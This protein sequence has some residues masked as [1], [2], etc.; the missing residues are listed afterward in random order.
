MRE[1]KNKLSNLG[2]NISILFTT[3]IIFFLMFEIILNFMGFL[4]NK[5]AYDNYDVEW[6]LFSQYDSDLGWKGKPFA[7]GYSK[8]D[9]SWIDPEASNK[10][11]VRNNSDGF[12][13]GEFD[14]DSDI[15]ILG[16]SIVWGYGVSE[17]DMFANILVQK[18]N[19]KIIN[20]GL[21]G[22]SPDQE[23]LLYERLIDKF[24]FKQTFLFVCENDFED[25]VNPTIPE[26]YPKPLF[27][28]KDNKLLLASVPAI[29]QSILWK[30]IHFM[31]LHSTIYNF[32]DV[33]TNFLLT[34]KLIKISNKE[35]KLEIKRSNIK[36]LELFLI[37]EKKINELT[38]SKNAELTV[39]LVPTREEIIQK[40]QKKYII[41][42]IEEITE[43]NKK[44]GIKTVN[45]YDSLINDKLRESLYR[46]VWHFSEYGNEVIANELTKYVY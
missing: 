37:L 43:T 1:T 7:Q 17:P 41:K 44:I 23:Y 21:P 19:K 26:N 36:P 22:Y 16:D 25:I 34:A 20:L 40:T 14:A 27:I 13:G 4:G 39:F 9:L 35:N 42:I 18:T 10:F 29:Q 32:V 31:K 12:R 28:K 45:L 6:S 24:N 8:A 11:F 3:I 33:K 15:V 5:D 30:I 38:K 46:D 2:I